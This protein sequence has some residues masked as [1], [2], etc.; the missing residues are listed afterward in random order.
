MSLIGHAILAEMVEMA[1]STPGGN[2]VEVGVYKGGSA[3]RLA[4]AAQEQGRRLWLF[5]TFTGMPEWTEG[6]DI[7]PVGHFG[8]TSLEAVRALVG[9]GEFVVGDARET[10]QAT[11]T[12]PLAFAH[13]DCD[14]YASVRACILELTSRMVR[15]GVIWFDDY[16]CLAGA[17]QAVDELMGDR[18]EPHP[19][20]KY[21]VRF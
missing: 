6:L 1:R 10:L 13:V 11:A 5:D 14:N 21:F 3:E 20:G 15:G 17:R 9:Y 7:R 16:D 12:G 18:I 8:D 4:A 19:C 2:W